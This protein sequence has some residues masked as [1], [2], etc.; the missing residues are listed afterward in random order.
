MVLDVLL[1]FVVPLLNTW[2]RT[3]VVVLMEHLAR[4]MYILFFDNDCLARAIAKLARS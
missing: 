3:V 2:K 4:L 1:S